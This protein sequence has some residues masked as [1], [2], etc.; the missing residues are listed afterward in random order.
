MKQNVFSIFYIFYVSEF[1]QKK[2]GG[3][4]QSPLS[5][6]HYYLSVL[7]ISLPYHSLTANE[8]P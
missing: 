3:P 7:F 8:I 1:M 4:T 2:K 6:N 5:I